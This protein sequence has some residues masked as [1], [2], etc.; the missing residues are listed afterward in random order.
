MVYYRPSLV[1]Y[2]YAGLI[3]GVLMG[4]LLR[5]SVHQIYIEASD[6]FYARVFNRKEL[7]ALL[8]QSYEKIS[9]TVVG[10]KAELFPIPRWQ[11]KERLEELTP[12]WF[13]S[14]ILSRWGSMIFVEAVKKG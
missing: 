12:D 11:A 1:Y 8:A 6:G 7:T 2:V 10:L 3:R 4:K 13:A 5:Q 9:T 14:A